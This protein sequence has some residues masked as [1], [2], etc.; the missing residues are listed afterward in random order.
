MAGFGRAA[1]GFGLIIRADGL[2]TYPLERVE[3]GGALF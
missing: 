1:F 2:G 3:S